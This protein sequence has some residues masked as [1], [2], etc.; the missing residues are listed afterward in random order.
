MTSEQ[1]IEAGTSYVCSALCTAFNRGKDLSWKGDVTLVLGAIAAAVACA[2]S[3]ERRGGNAAVPQ[4]EVDG[5][6]DGSGG[7]VDPELWAESA[8]TSRNEAAASRPS[9]VLFGDSITQFSFNPELCGWG[10]SVASWYARQADVLNRGFSGYNTRQG[11]IVLK[12]LLPMSETRAGSQPRLLTIMFGANDAADAVCN[13]RQHVPVSEYESNLRD[14]IAHARSACPGIIVVL[15]TPPPV[16]EGAYAAHNLK[17]KRRKASDPIDRS[18]A[19]VQP[20]V[21]A[22]D[23]VAHSL[24]CPV[25]NLWDGTLLHALLVAFVIGSYGARQTINGHPLKVACVPT[26]V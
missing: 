21:E 11:L 2:A 12:K 1:T 4:E 22:V 24:D 10:A 7:S 3:L 9:I 20:Y 5:N 19:R 14:M 23:R 26:L 13:A 17:L 8:T 15:I 18:S 6:T 16:D 25:V